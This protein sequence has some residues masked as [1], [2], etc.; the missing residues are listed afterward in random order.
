MEVKKI[1]D[2]YFTFKGIRHHKKKITFTKEMLMEFIGKEWYYYFF[3]EEDKLKR[4]FDKLLIT[5]RNLGKTF[6]VVV[7]LIYL[8]INEDT[9]NAIVTRKYAGLTGELYGMFNRVFN[10]LEDYFEI[11]FEIKWQQELPR[12]YKRDKDKTIM[13]DDEGNALYKKTKYRTIKS[14]TQLKGRNID[15]LFMYGKTEGDKF[16]IFYQCSHNKTKNRIIYFRGADDPDSS[17]GL[18]PNVGYIW[19]IFHEEFSQETDKGKLSFDQQLVRYA[20]LHTTAKRYLNEAKL[21]GS[22]P[23]NARV[24][25]IGAANAWDPEHPWIVAL[26]SVIGEKEWRAFV[27]EDVENNTFII[28]ADEESKVEFFR[29]TTLHNTFQF[30][31]DSVIREQEVESSLVVLHGPNEYLKAQ[32]LGFVFPGFMDDDSPMEAIINLIMN[33][34]EMSADELKKS[35]WT[36]TAAEFGA[37]PGQRDDAVSL[38][39][40]LIN[41]FKE[42]DFGDKVVNESKLYIGELFVIENKLRKKNKQQRIPNPV[43]KQ[44]FLEF[45]V[46]CLKRYPKKMRDF[47]EVNMDMRALAIRDDFNYDIFPKANIN[48]QCVTFPANENNGFGLEQRPD[49]LQQIIPET[50]WDPATKARVLIALK[51]LKRFAPDKKQ[52]HPRKGDMDIYDTLCYGIVKLRAYL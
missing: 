51:S 48:G 27:A 47:L 25:V 35:E 19:I 41:T 26:L 38:E 14:I 43:M 18:A 29:A 22:A 34:P 11:S 50:I 8:M 31:L 42:N 5:A 23:A 28:R 16:A 15:A 9:F 52:P 2:W 33:A 39:V 17:R 36:R 3:D 49:I 40:N 13:K 32:D 21:N 6:K 30:P 46:S 20:S 45:W 12:E 24:L 10:M 37:D 7:V 4:D 44:M 1:V